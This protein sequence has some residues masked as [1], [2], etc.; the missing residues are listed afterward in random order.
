MKRYRVK[1][2]D[3]Q[4][5]VIEEMND[6]DIDENTD[7]VT[8]ADE[9]TFDEITALKEL[10]GLLPKLKNLLDIEN[11]EH[12]VTEDADEEIDEEII[13][14]EDED[15]KIVDTDKKRYAKDSKNSVGA[16]QRKT[17]VNDNIDDNVDIEKA[18][19]KRYGGN[20]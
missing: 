2:A 7:I 20:K 15:E 1:D 11:A 14:S 3:E 13:D 18:W 16:I 4:E 17:K 9:L 10:V 5:Y 8:D 12:E 19:S 6:E